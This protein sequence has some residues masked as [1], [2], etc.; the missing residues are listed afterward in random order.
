M[1]DAPQAHSGWPKHPDGRPKKMGEMTREERLAQWR[2]AS[3][4]IKGELETPAMQAAFANMLRGHRP[5]TY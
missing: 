2:S 4:K 5:S 3:L 1:S